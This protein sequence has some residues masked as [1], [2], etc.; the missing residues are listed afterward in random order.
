M[1]NEN[2]HETPTNTD[3]KCSVRIKKSGK[4]YRIFNKKSNL[5]EIELKDVYFK[6][7]IED[8]KSKK[9]LNIYIDKHNDAYSNDDYNNIADLCSYVANVKKL[10]DDVYEFRRLGLDGK[11]FQTPIKD[12]K[13]YGK[14][15]I[16]LRTYLDY[17]VDMCMKGVFGSLDPSTDIKG[18]RGDVTLFIKTLWTTNNN[19]GVI[20]YTKIIDLDRRVKEPIMDKKEK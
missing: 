11:G 20:I 19:Y 7:G 6:F 18:Y 14:D 9:V 1:T 17:N 12:I 13:E 3:I 4:S 5:I 2:R 8:Y 16:S 15:I 10:K